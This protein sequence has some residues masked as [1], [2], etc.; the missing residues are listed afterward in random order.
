MI[1]HAQIVESRTTPGHHP[2][3][4]GAIPVSALHFR[5]GRIDEANAMVLAYHY[6][7]RIASNVQMVSSLHLDGGLFGGDGAMVAAAF[8]TFPPTRWKE[9]VIELA[10][11]VRGDLSVP[12]T[13]LI[14]KSVKELRRQGHDLLVSFADRTQGHDG[15]VYRASNWNYA[16]LRDRQ[17]DGMV[18][19]GTFKPGRSCNKVFGTRSL[20]K[21]RAMFPNKTIEAHWDEGKHCYWLPL[22]KRGEEKASRLGLRTM[23]DSPPDK[24]DEPKLNQSEPSDGQP[25]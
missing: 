24:P 14:S 25:S 11:L 4:E 22:G 10:R 20:D 18:I 13:F 9:P 8:W 23:K 17:N 2:G 16:G 7:R 6:S 12:L 1:E 21:L 15:Y 19:D 5:T 3:G